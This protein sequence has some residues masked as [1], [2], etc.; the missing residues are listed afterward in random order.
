M[1]LFGI[2]HVLSLYRA[3]GT[4]L[5]NYHN[6]KRKIAVHHISVCTYLYVYGSIDVYTLMS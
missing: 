5:Q 4:C 2:H 6:T 1:Q 3:I